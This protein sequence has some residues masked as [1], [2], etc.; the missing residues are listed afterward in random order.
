MRYTF[1]DLIAAAQAIDAVERMKADLA[2]FA[3]HQCLGDPDAEGV[4]DFLDVG[5]GDAFDVPPAKAMEYFK[6]KGLR[7]T[8]SYADMLGEAHDKAFTVAKMMDADLLATVRNS[9][10]AALSTGTSFKEWTKELAPILKSAGWWGDADMI[11]PATG[12]KVAARL[13]SAWRLETIFRTNMQTAYAAGQWR[14]IEAQA[15]VAPFLLYDAVDDYRT[16]PLH[17][18]WDSTVLPVSSPWWKTHYPPNGWNCRCGVIQLDAEQLRDM[19]LTPRA[20]PPSD[21]EVTWTNPRTGEVLR[22][23]RGVDPGFDRNAGAFNDD[24][25]R[26]LLNEKVA[27]LPPEMRQAIEQVIR[28]EFNPSTQ[29]GRWNL[30]AFDDAADWIRNKVLDDPEVDVKFEAKDAY[31]WLGKLIDMDGLKLDTKNGQSVWRHEFGHIIDVRM[32][33]E[34]TY[35]SSHRDFLLAM[36]ADA[37]TLLSGSAKGRPSK[38]IDARKAE[39][40]QA[41]ESAEQRLV[42]TPREKRAEVLAEMAVVAGLDF[43]GFLSVVRDSTL[44]LDVQGVESVANAARL[45]KMIEAVRQ[46]DGEGFLRWASYKDEIDLMVATRSYDR[47]TIKKHGDSWRK[48]G[49]MSSLSDMMGA[50]TRNKV[51]DFKRGF[52]GHT[53]QYYREYGPRQA[54]EAF[55]N[56]TALAGHEN[57][58]W[59]T[60]ARRFAPNMADL[61]RLIIE[62]EA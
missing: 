59:W 8:F 24:T 13:G 23:P 50:A 51:S 47:D 57:R 28:R 34:A 31:A 43:D 3:A 26:Q 41:Y 6:A 46:G 25:I 14:Q 52:P 9:L 15:D 32:G 55:A 16:R 12:E 37:K 40:T 61:Y 7:T 18:S 19:G 39:L 4:I 42:D 44:V 54:T 10:D 29:A 62:G 30:A 53:D 58:Y 27:N 56:L 60:L 1:R 20:D 36:D 48:D 21:G 33:T 38:A 2:E 35:R 45:A 17:A 11:D 22:V 5:T 49:S